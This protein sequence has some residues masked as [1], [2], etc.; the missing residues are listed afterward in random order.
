MTGRRTAAAT[1]L[2]ASA[3]ASDAIGKPGLDD[4]DAEGV[5]LP[6]QADLLVDPHRE[7]RRLLAVAQG[8]VEH[9]QAVAFHGGLHGSTCT[10]APDGPQGY[11]LYV[12]I[13]N[14]NL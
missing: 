3:S 4:V 1:A 13:R 2:T 11:N 5:E 12:F 6:G 8:R 9:R 7:S 10:M 14:A